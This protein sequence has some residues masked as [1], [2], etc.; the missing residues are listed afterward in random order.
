MSR[1]KKNGGCFGI[2]IGPGIAFFALVAIWKNEARFDY[3]RA[4]ARTPEVA[5]LENASEDQR[6]SHTGPM[7]Q[8]LTMPAGYVESFSGYLKVWRTA[9]I[10]AWDKDTDSDNHTTWNKE[11]MSS[12]ESNSRNRGIKQTLASK[13]F[14]PER[15][16]VGDLS[17]DAEMIEFVDSSQQILPKQLELTRQGLRVE[18]KYFYLRKNQASNLGDERVSYS[19]IPVPATA[20][21]FGKYSGGIAVADTTNMRTGFINQLIQD[22]GI[23][24]HLVAGDRTTALATMKAYIGRLKWI[25]RGIGTAAVVLGMFIMFASMFGFLFHIPIIGRIAESGSFLLA[26][27]IGLPLAIVTMVASYFVA[28]PMILVA[29]IAII[30]AALYLMRRRAKKTQDAVQSDLY[31]RYG[32]TLQPLEVKE[33]EFVELAK[34]AMSDAQLGSDEEKFLREWASNHKWDDAK[35]DQMLQRAKD[36]EHADGASEVSNDEHLMNL[37]RLALADGMV[38]AFEIRAI[39]TTAR[40]VGYD[41]KTIDDLTNQVREMALTGQAV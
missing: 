26:L 5:Q 14:I 39:R 11:W 41:D 17:I 25:I 6:L 36:E 4:A 2:L 10:Y 1:Q 18:G 33:L 15:F 35:F 38:S 34:L 21:Y 37:I 8:S 31:Q 19:G 7:D 24:H 16:Q 20:T 32:H 27:A 40:R 30:I 3:H 12:V 22:T 9:E 13:N 28:H 23:L 29:I